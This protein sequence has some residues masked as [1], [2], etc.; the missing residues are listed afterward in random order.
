[1]SAEDDLIGLLRRCHLE[2]EALAPRLVV[3]D[4]LEEH[5]KTEAEAAL[6][7]ILRRASREHYIYTDPLPDILAADKAA[8]RK[9]ARDWL[10]DLA[11]R[12]WGFEH[13]LFSLKCEARELLDSYRSPLLPGGMAW[14]ARLKVENIRA[15]MLPG[16]LASPWLT[17]FHGVLVLSRDTDA[18]EGIVEAFAAR[19]ALRTL[20]GLVLSYHPLG[21]VLPGLCGRGPW[22]EVVTLE[23]AHAG[24]G[25]KELKTLA[26]SPLARGV[27]LFKGSHNKIISPGVSALCAACPRLFALHLDHN[28]ITDAGAKAIARLP[29]LRWLNLY[30]NPRMTLKG[31]RAII[32]GLAPTL[33]YLSLPNISAGDELADALADGA[34]TALTRLDVSGEASMTPAGLQRLIDAPSL[35][36]LIWLGS[37]S[38]ARAHRGIRRRE[39]LHL[40]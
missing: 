6:I 18:D 17:N 11:S 29:A 37:P 2:P 9:H 1:M 5:G 21:D 4:W 31:V 32:D 35:R 33:H 20:T 23:M 19:S 34:F 36:T 15:G 27:R 28:R 40:Q 12:S 38:A 10:G 7:P 25:S 16:V 39:G 26:G 8:V 13:G 24:L 3:A 22:G 30:G 14:L